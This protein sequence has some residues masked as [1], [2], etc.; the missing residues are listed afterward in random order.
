MWAAGPAM[1]LALTHS[2]RT[3]V[4]RDRAASI[5]MG[6]GLLWAIGLMFV[7]LPAFAAAGV[8]PAVAELPRFVAVMIGAVAIAA[9]AG[10]LYATPITETSIDVAD[11]IVLIRR[12]R[13]FRTVETRLDLS[14]IRSALVARDLDHDGGE[15]F[16]LFL[17]TVTGEAHA[18]S[19]RHAG[20]RRLFDEA[21]GK[22]DALVFQRAVV[23]VPPSAPT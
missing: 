9:G 5:R 1:S 19:S 21:K 12:R 2:P 8:G 22:I 20:S 23:G 18:L 16:R 7:I 3:L 14:V 10:L 17:I 6:A 4:V 11:G 13:V 15:A